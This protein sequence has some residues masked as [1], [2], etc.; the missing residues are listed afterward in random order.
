MIAE[1]LPPA[2]DL[3]TKDDIRRLDVKIDGVEARMDVRFHAL[4]AK[5]YRW[6]LTFFVPLWLGV[7]GVLA[8]LVLRGL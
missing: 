2:A 8:A 4:E 6:N 5:I 7:W 1:A 3:A